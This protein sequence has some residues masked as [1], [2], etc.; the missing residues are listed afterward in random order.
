MAIMIGSHE[1]S[2]YDKWVAAMKDAAPAE[3]RQELKIYRTIDGR[4]VVT[5]ETF[6]TLENAEKHLAFL[7]N[8]ENQPIG[9]SIGVIFPITVWIVE[10]V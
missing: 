6:D 5:N 3:G 8:P 10:E 1:V 4:R 9:E 7:E 2:D